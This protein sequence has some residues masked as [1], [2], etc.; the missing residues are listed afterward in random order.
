MTAVPTLLLPAA[1]ELTG[2]RLASSAAGLSGHP[3]FS[4]ADIGTLDGALLVQ[5]PVPRGQILPASGAAFMIV[6]GWAALQRTT[7]R[8]ETQI[9]GFFLPGDF[10]GLDTATAPMGGGEVVALTAMRIRRLKQDGRS[11][12]ASTPG[13]IRAIAAQNLKHQG[14]LQDQIV[15]LGAMTALERTAHLLAELDGR[16]KRGAASSR[17]QSFPIRQEI[18]SQAL[19]LSLVHVN[20]TL[21]KLRHQALAW[22]EH[23]RLLVPD[24]AALL[25]AGAEEARAPA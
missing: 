2:L 7:A 18:L 4:S 9:L 25:S 21:T 20:R 15:R 5:A 11:I 1:R 10:V 14:R 19:G 6:A 13:L 23:G 17:P 8:G 3:D 22:F 12:L 24:P 16:L